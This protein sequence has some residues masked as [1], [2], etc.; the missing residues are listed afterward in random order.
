MKKISEKIIIV[1]LPDRGFPEETLREEKVRVERNY[2]MT[3]DKVPEAF[4]PEIA[5]NTA[6]IAEWKALYGIGEPDGQATLAE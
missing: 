5:K 1:P 3:L 6:Q 2:C 4:Y